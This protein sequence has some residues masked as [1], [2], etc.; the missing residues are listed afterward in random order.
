[1]VEAGNRLYIV[2]FAGVEVL[3]VWSGERM[4]RMGVVIESRPEYVGL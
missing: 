4:G 3:T 1:M 2:E